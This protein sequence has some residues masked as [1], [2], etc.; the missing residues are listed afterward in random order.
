MKIMTNAAQARIESLEKQI[1]NSEIVSI[2]PTDTVY[3]II[4]DA[5]NEE[6]IKKVYMAKRRS[7]SKPLII[8]VSS[9]EMLKRYVKNISDVEKRLIEKY[10]PGRL[11]ILFKRNNKISDFLTNSGDYIGIRLP[12]NKELCKLM[13]MLNKPLVS[14]SANIS[15]NMTITEI[16]M[17]EDELKN[18]IS[19]IVD[20]GMLNDLPSTLIKV[21]DEK[22]IFLREG[23]LASNIRKDFQ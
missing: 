6:A 22:I 14:T 21:E 18:N 8:M 3:G 5:T 13:N 4:A 20:G 2:V 15:D 1:D 11:T 23:E 12:D 10:W 9:I 17:L 19:Y 7:F 16:S